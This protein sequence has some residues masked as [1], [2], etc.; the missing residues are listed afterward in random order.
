MLP[1]SIEMNGFSNFTIFFVFGPV[2][3]NLG[4]QSTQYQ[5]YHRSMHFGCFWWVSGETVVTKTSPNVF[6]LINQF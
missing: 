4:K 1:T 5:R 3:V 2:L 6:D